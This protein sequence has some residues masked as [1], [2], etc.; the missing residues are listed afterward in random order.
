MTRPLIRGIGVGPGDPELL[1]IRAAEALR[2]A[3]LVV[4]PKATEGSE[5][6]ALKIAAAYIA[7]GCA[8][9]EIVF[10]MSQADAAR[11]AA[12]NHAADLLAKRAARGEPAVFVTL[13]DAML[14]S[15]WGYVLAALRERHPEH[16]AETVPGVTAASAAAAR[17]GRPLAEGA[18]PLVF[19]PLAHGAG[20]EALGELLEVAPNVVALKSGRHVDRLVAAARQAGAE[21]AAVSNVG[22]AGE[23]VATD[24]EEFAGES[25]GYFTTV[26]VHKER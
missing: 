22:M 19:W 6:V 18:E 26:L 13:G 5:S 21:I 3:T 16:A 25:L 8:V 11:E 10:P 24:A 12:A 4:T 7:P 9:A 20:P 2:C 15:T 23:R 17:L 1:T 14:Y